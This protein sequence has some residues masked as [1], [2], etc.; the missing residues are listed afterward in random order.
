MKRTLSLRRETLTELTAEDLAGIA[1]G[2]EAITP[3][4]PTVP[5]KYCFSLA[6]TCWTTV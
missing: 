5:V 1:A 2:D 4:C 6:P 3:Y